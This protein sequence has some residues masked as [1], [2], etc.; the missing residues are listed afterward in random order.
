MLKFAR[1][2]RSSSADRAA[3][4]AAAPHRNAATTHLHQKRS[5]PAFQKTNTRDFSPTRSSLSPSPR[6]SRRTTSLERTPVKSRRHLNFENSIP[7][8][9]KFNRTF[10]NPATRLPGCATP[11]PVMKR[12]ALRPR[13]PSP[14]EAS[15]TSDHYRE[16]SS[17]TLCRLAPMTP[18]LEKL[19]SAHVSE[20]VVPPV[21]PKSVLKRGARYD[22]HRAVERLV[23]KL[24]L[25]LMDTSSESGYG[26]E[27]E[28]ESLNSVSSG[29]STSPA[30]VELLTAAPPPLPKRRGKR[31]VHFDSY[32]L[33][34]QGLKER[35]LELVQA[36]VKEVCREAMTTDE[37]TMEAMRCVVDGE[38]GIL[39]EL[40]SHGFDANFTDPAGL[41]PL[42]LAAAFNLLPV[43]K[44]LLSHGAAINAR[45]HSSGQTPPAMCSP[46]VPNH[47]ACQAYLRCMEECLG[48]ANGGAAY[49]ARHYRTSRSDELCVAA[50]ERVVV[51]R[52]GDYDGSAWWWCENGKGEQGYVL[53]DILALNRP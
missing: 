28:A 10:V 34:L 5:P 11:P 7:A 24:D 3:V 17:G 18:T 4:V 35:N 49:T 40:L 46:R 26:S 27:L 47:E 16:L 25:Q 50:A 22:F 8:S 19:A 37:V 52:K 9:P 2:S 53:K 31:R 30:S 13:V 41:T 44:L 12:A 6:T 23:E 14:D 33:L 15:V 48:V 1:R 36:N 21:L 45:A 32:V 38:E 39:R 42:H 51:R 43:I 20:G 29:N